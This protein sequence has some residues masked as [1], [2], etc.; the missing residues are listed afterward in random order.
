MS[1]GNS[2]SALSKHPPHSA[3]DNNP[4]RS[5]QQKMEDRRKVIISS[6]QGP[7]TRKQSESFIDWRFIEDVIGQPFDSKHIPLSKLFHMRRDPMLAFA[8]HFVKVPLVRAQW[9]I[10]SED[11]QVAA[12]VDGALR[13]IYAR[14]IFQLCLDM[15]F[16]YSAIVKRFSFDR[17]EWTYYDPHLPPAEAR[18]QKAWDEGPIRAIVWKPFVPL[19]P[20]DVEPIWTDAGDFNG[21]KYT[22]ESYQGR[23]NLR[24]M[25]DSAEEVDILH[26]LWSTNER[27]SEFGSIYGYPRLGYAFPYWWSYKYNYMLADRYF[28]KHADPPPLV[29]YP[30]EEEEVVTDSGDTVNYKELALLLGESVRSGASIAL[31]SSVVQ[32]FDEKPTTMRE[33]EISFLQPPSNF[34]AFNQRFEYLDVMKLRSM[35]VPE[36]AFIESRGGSSSKNVAAT[37]GDTFHE[38]QA[39]KMDEIADIINRY[40]IP[41]LLAVNFPER[42]AEAKFVARGFQSEDMEL[43][44]QLIQ[45]IGQQDANSLNVDV[46]ELLN[47][48]GIPLKSPEEIADEQRKLQEQIAASTPPPT[49]AVPGE[50]AGVAPV[51]EVPGA[52]GRSNNPQGVQTPGV[53][54][55]SVT[56]FGE[57]MYVR[58]GDRIIL[59]PLWQDA[60]ARRVIDKLHLSV[61]YVNELLTDVPGAAARYDR[62]N[63]RVFIKKGTPI[64]KASSY[65]KMLGLTEA[66]VA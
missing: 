22:G 59:P 42:D 65:I 19:P 60:E 20:D 5:Q 32:G 38:S 31:P 16:G 27:D 18:L 53:P 8:L 10:K 47:N 33:W 58:Q 46:R 50:Q 11:A 62:E 52:A 44:K 64:E 56:G 26:A 9:F 55:G 48:A 12:F 51:E 23:L 3:P 2:V 54:S 61:S 14:L 63:R 7:S 37:M 39:I 4:Q 21:I 29:H 28:E 43:A 66:E 49:D 25:G 15:D 17:P 41:Q 30:S 45:L 57:T 36:Q 6:E 40:L 13:R 35:M 34:E 24:T 1:N